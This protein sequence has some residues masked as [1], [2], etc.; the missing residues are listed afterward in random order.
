M[1][2]TVVGINHRGAPLDIRE[3]VA[4][5]AERD[6]AARSTRC[7]D[8]LRRARG[9]AAVDV[10]SHRGLSRRGRDA[11]PRRPSGRRS[12]RDSARDA[13]GLRLRATRPGGG[14]ASLPR[15]ERSRFDGARRGADSRPGARRVGGVPRALRAGAQSPVS[16]VA[17]RRRPR[18]ERD[19]DRARRGVGELG[20]R[21]AREADL[22]I[23]RRQ[24]RHGARRRR[25]GGAGARVSGRSG[26]ARRR[27]SPTARSSAR[28]SSPSGYGAVAMHYDECWTALADVDVL[29]CSTAAPHAGRRSSSTC[30][31]RSARAAIGR[32]AFSTSRC[33]A[34][35]IRRS[36]SSSNVF[37]YNLDDLQAVV[38]ANLER[39]R[40]R[41]ADG[42]GA[43]RRRSGA[44]LGMG[45]RARGG[46]G[47][48]ARCATRMDAVRARELAEALRRLRPPPAGR[49]R[50]RRRTFQ[51]HS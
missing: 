38:S 18:A 35:S 47:A 31:R 26:R 1:A 25:D 22:R 21:A 16:D 34:T 6:R 28:R 37:L 4:Y 51:E 13:S 48:D 27:S 43:D 23:A 2:L 41:A 8:A 30:G 45:R 24:A 46:A 12:R 9:R 11:T 32:S 50:R 7:R 19:V 40:A 44:V 17:A 49:P 3:R 15:R 14:R 36:A 10:Q 42:R 39:R 5:R 33:R 29:V 20:G